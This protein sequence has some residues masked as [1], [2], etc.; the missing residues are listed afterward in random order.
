MLN[1]S[2]WHPA[3]WDPATWFTFIGVIVAVLALL[4]AVLTFLF[5]DEIHAWLKVTTK[6]I[7]IPRWAVLL[8]ALIVLGILIRGWLGKALFQIWSVIVQLRHFFSQTIL[9]PRWMVFSLWFFSAIALVALAYFV[10]RLL[11]QAAINHNT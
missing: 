6:R 2:T 5:K 9:I 3:N 11:R 7:P 4:F 1:Q 8:I 10:S